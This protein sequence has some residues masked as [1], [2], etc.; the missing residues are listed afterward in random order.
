MDEQVKLGFEFAKGLSEQ[1]I[2]ISTGILA[3]SITFTKDLVD[4]IPPRGT[5]F[6][7]ISW[8]LFVISIVCGLD[9]LSALTGQLAP[10]DPPAAQV[11][12]TATPAPLATES[13]GNR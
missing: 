2:T 11:G 12:V 5:I 10:R 9:H 8:L 3:L 13:H 7:G 6:L 1:L 4:R